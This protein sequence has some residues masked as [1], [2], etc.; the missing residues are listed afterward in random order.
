MDYD[1]FAPI[2]L[3]IQSISQFATSKLFLSCM[4]I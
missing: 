3:V 1:Q 4:S 2:R